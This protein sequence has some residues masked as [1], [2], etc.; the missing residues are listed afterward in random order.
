[1]L[2]L[3]A[4]GIART[5]PERAG[6]IAGEAGDCL[7]KHLPDRALY[8]RTIFGVLGGAIEPDLA[9]AFLGAIDDP[10]WR[11]EAAYAVTVATAAERPEHA[12][13]VARSIA[14]ESLAE[15]LAPVRPDDAERIARSVP[16]VAKGVDSYAPHTA[17][18]AV[19]AALVR[20]DPERADRIVGSVMYMGADLWRARELGVAL[21]PTHPLRAEQV[22]LAAPSYVVFRMERIRTLAAVGAAM[23]AVDPE[24]AGRLIDQAFRTAGR[25]MHPDRAGEVAGM[26]RSRSL[27]FGRSE[28]LRSIALGLIP[29]AADLSER[30]ARSIPDQEPRD[31]ALA[32][33]ALGIG[34][35]DPDKAER[36]V[37]DIEGVPARATALA[38]L[39]HVLGG[40]EPNW[41]E[42][43]LLEE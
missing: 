7:P 35:A 11:A 27:P 21:A 36:I 8:R 1:L 3:V 18:E 42:K 15:A 32:R 9:D 31:M 22:A 25:N 29:G 33:L 40:H 37:R 34:R 17:L 12:E 24:R 26:L 30:V 5:D 43:A 19:A 4:A 13:K 38:R 6:R 28:A 2:G 20:T 39:A 14:V 41:R 10:G 23:T 16:E